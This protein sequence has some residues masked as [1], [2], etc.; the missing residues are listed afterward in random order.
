MPITNEAMLNVG[1]YYMQ[2]ISP[3]CLTFIP[4]FFLQNAGEHPLTITETTPKV[5]YARGHSIFNQWSTCFAK[6]FHPIRGSK[7]EQSFIQNICST[8]PGDS[9]AT[10]DPESTMFPITFYY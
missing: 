4:I 9:V 1:D 10:L 7:V 3:Y 6:D 5:Q 2:N 8:I